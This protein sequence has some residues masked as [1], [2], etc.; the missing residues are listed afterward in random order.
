MRLSKSLEAQAPEVTPRLGSQAEAGS[1]VPSSLALS[2]DK[3]VQEH[4][5]LSPER[6]ESDQL[7][8]PSLEPSGPQQSVQIQSAQQQTA[9]KQHYQQQ[10]V[11]GSSYFFFKGAVI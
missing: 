3:Q 7:P 10:Q 9:L 8:M 5:L 4:V 11:L 2:N 1:S 6:R